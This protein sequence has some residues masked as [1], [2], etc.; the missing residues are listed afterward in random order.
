M[1]KWKIVF[2]NVIFIDVKSKVLYR[3]SVLPHNLKKYLKNKLNCYRRQGLEFSHISELIITSITSLDYMTYKQDI[4]QPMAM[5][6][7]L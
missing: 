4:E 3:I 6:E 2:D 5:V 7:K 1:C